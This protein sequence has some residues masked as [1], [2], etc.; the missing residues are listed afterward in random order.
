MLSAMLKGELAVASRDREKHDR[1][2]VAVQDQYG[3]TVAYFLSSLERA[4][5]AIRK[6]PKEQVCC[7]LT[8]LEGFLKINIEL[9]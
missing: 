9:S 8:W 6:P 2:R 3:N 5:D 4:D 1:L 7:M